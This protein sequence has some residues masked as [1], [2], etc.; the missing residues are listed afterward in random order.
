[1]PYRLATS[2]DGTFA[3]ACDPQAGAIHVIDVATR[4]ISWKLDGLGSPRGVSIAADGK[5]AFVTLADGPSVGVVDLVTRKLSR[6]IG[7]GASPD[8]VGYGPTP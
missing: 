5:T 4:K 6:T 3:I 2:A 8:G 1:M 7:V